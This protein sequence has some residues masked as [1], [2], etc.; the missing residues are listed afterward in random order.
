MADVGMAEF[1]MGRQ[2]RVLMA[3]EKWWPLTG[4]NDKPNK[5]DCSGFVRSVAT[6]LGIALAGDANKIYDTIQRAPWSQLG[7][8]DL[9]AH[10]AA[11]AAT[12][13]KFVVGAWR[14]P[15]PGGNGHVAIIVDT[16]YSAS[17]VLH[18]TRAIA[19]WGTLGAEGRQYR[20]HS[21]SWGASIRAQVLYAAC[22]V[23]S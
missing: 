17:T 20:K 4:P 21:E 11:V 22:D 14:N 23:S 2:R 3:C 19:Y 9:A 13:G 10:L 1:Q 7:T 8:G 16:N 12:N 18:R 6:E 5:S 15:N